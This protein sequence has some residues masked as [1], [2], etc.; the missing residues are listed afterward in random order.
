[1]GNN[2]RFYSH[3]HKNGSF[4]EFFNTYT[5]VTNSVLTGC[6]TKLSL[7]V[8][9]AKNNTTQ[10]QIANYIIVTNK[11]YGADEGIEFT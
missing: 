1:M 6:Y 3:K 5:S 2:R 7:N 4:Q 11:L 8:K 9:N 10:I